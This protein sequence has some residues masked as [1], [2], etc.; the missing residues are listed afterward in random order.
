[1]NRIT[2]H[3]PSPLRDFT[4]GDAELVVEAD[5]VRD[6]LE[7]IGERHALLLPR[8]LTRGGDLRPYVNLFLDEDDIRS[9]NGLETPVTGARELLVVPSVAGG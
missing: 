1:M 2:V 4:G 8:I 7:R 9:L 6:A 5:C 3:I